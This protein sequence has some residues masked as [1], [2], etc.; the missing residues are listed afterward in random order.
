MSHKIAKS[1]AILFGAVLFSV[2]PVFVHAATNWYVDGSAAG[3]GDGLSHVNATTTI[4][5]A[6]N[7][8][9][10]GDTILV[11]PGH[12]QETAP[13]S[14]LTTS[15]GAG[16]YTFGLFLP[17]AKPGITIEGVDAGG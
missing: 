5:A 14:T 2:S 16:T 1:L 11:Y 17:F 6:I 8:A 15:G 9:T 7:A 4:Q 10:A 3:T 13:N 12:Y